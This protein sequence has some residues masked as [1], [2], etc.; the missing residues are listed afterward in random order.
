ME[1]NDDARPGAVAVAM[2]RRKRSNVAIE[3][4]PSSW[5]DSSATSSAGSSAAASFHMAR[6]KTRQVGRSRT[7]TSSKPASL[8][9]WPRSTLRS[10]AGNRSSLGSMGSQQVS[11]ARPPG[12]RTRSSSR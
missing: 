9:P 12:A 3:R 4:T 1:L 8:N 6:S 2:T 5:K 7:S 11:T 10:R